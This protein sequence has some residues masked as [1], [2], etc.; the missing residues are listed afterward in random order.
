MDALKKSESYFDRYKEHERLN[1][2]LDC[3]K[4]LIIAHEEL[5]YSGK[6]EPRIQARDG[7]KDVRR[8]ILRVMK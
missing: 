3:Y 2:L 6:K 1:D 4:F 8:E 7:L 5:K